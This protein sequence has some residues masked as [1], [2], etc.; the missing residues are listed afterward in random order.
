M[1]TA[2]NRVGQRCRNPAQAVLDLLLVGADGG[3][4]PGHIPVGE[5][6][7]GDADGHEYRLVEEA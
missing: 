5:N 4:L 3:G 2:G 6:T 7:G 1:G